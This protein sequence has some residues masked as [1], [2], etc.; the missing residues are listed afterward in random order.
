MA[1]SSYKKI[2]LFLVGAGFIGIV[3][4]LFILLGPPQLLAKSGK[5]FFVYSVM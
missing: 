4:L 1:E 3:T 5:P 2:V